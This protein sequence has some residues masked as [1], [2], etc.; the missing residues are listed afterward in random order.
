MRRVIVVH[1]MQRSGNHAIIHWLKAHDRFIFINNVIPIAPI[2]KE[3]KRIPP[4]EK[5]TLWLLRRLLQRKLHFPFLLK[6]FYL[7]RHSLIVSIEDHDLQVRPVV[8]IPYAVSNILIIRDPRNLFS[9]RIRRAS[10]L[11]NHPAYPSHTGPAMNR[12]VKL[13]KSHAREYLGLTSHIE[14]RANIYF[15]FWFSNRDYRQSIS[16]KLNMEF[17]DHSFSRVAREGGGSSFDGTHFDGNNQM[18]DVLNRQ[19]SLTDPERHLLETILADEELKELAQRVID[20]NQ[21]V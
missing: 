3:T 9:S 19:S 2:L 10:L 20:M 7:Q 5:F 18:M 14:N 12:V 15:D 17:T 1:G 13:W 4:P 21:V 11:K 6:K 8:Q 16:R